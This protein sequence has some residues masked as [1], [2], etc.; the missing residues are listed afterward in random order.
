MKTTNPAPGNQ[1]IKRHAIHRH[2][3]DVCNESSQDDD[4]KL[5]PIRYPQRRQP[6]VQVTQ[7]FIVQDSRCDYEQTAEKYDKGHVC[8]KKRVL[9]PAAEKRVDQGIT[10]ARTD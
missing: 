9:R 1:R 4:Y 5:C 8:L 6:N 7:N 10:L 3:G 2:F